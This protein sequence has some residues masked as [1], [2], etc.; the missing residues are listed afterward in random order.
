MSCDVSTEIGLFVL[1]NVVV[2][3]L[4]EVQEKNHTIKNCLLLL[5]CFTY[6]FNKKIN[7]NHVKLL[8]I[9]FVSFIYLHRGQYPTI[10]KDYFAT[11]VFLNILILSVPL[12]YEKK[13]NLAIQLLVFSLLTPKTFDESHKTKSWV[14][15]YIVIISSF[16]VHASPFTETSFQALMS[17]FPMLIGLFLSV[18][19]S[20]EYRIVGMLVLTLLSSFSKSL[21]ATSKRFGSSKFNK[22]SP[23]EAFCT[24]Y[25][26]FISDTKKYIYYENI[27]LNYIALLFYSLI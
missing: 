7:I 12:F 11:S 15:T 27:K 6:T 16:F 24:K 17:I 1:I 4:S 21:F 20:I 8:F 25:S 26:D 23:L 10:Y 22:N 18:E 2:V 14:I 19:K 9:L 3:L 5:P 13:Y